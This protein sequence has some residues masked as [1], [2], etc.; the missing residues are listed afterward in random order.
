[1]GGTEHKKT[2]IPTIQKINDYFRTSFIKTIGIDFVV[3]QD[4]FQIWDTA[5]QARFF[6]ITKAYFQNAF[7]ILHF[8]PTDFLSTLES[9]LRSAPDL[10]YQH[11][12]VNYETSSKTLPAG[13]I[14]LKT[15]A[16]IGSLLNLE[17]LTPVFE[18]ALEARAFCATDPAV[19]PETI[20]SLLDALRTPPDLV[21]KKTPRAIHQDKASGR[22][23]A[24]M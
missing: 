2:F 7:A 22:S 15:S 9:T 17:E 12:A 13:K 24:V 21:L 10:L 20:T 14:Q 11:Y 1:L 18:K 5:G 23:C 3:Y 6:N 16:S 4:T 19:Y 8:G